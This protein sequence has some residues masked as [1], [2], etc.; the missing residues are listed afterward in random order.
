MN[1]ILKHFFLSNNIK[2]ET[3]IECL[4]S[5]LII[6]TPEEARER[7]ETH[8][9]EEIRAKMAFSIQLPRQ[10]TEGDEIEI[11]GVVHEPLQV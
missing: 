3:L 8:E 11:C 5:C 7:R 9:L 6:R 1:T 4:R 10:P 2:L